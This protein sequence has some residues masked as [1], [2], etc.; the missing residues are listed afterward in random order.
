MKLLKPSCPSGS[1]TLPTITASP[2][3]RTARQ[4][5]KYLSYFGENFCKYP[6]IK[7]QGS[8]NQIILLDFF[9]QE[10]RVFLQRLVIQD[11]QLR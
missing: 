4:E 10:F 8:S 9:L 5:E 3:L 1:P 7:L 2:N 11:Q 6:F